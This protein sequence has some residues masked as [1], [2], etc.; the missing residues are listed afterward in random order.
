MSAVSSFEQRNTDFLI[1]SGGPGPVVSIPHSYDG[2]P[3]PSYSVYPTRIV[4]AVVVAVLLAVPGRGEDGD[5][6]G[7]DGDDDD[8]GVCRRAMASWWGRLCAPRVYPVVPDGGWGW[9]V[10]GALFSISAV[11]IGSFKAYGVFVPELMAHFDTHARGVSWIFS[12]CMFVVAFCAPVTTVLGNRFSPRAV[13][14][15]GGVITSVGTMSTALS[16]T[17]THAYLTLG[18][19]TGLG[20]SLSTLPCYSALSC[21]FERRRTLA[22]ALATTGECLGTFAFAPGFQR[23]NEAV[24]WRHS[25]LVIGAGQA[26]IVACGVLLRPLELRAPSPADRPGRRQPC[27]DDGAAVTAAATIVIMRENEQTRTTV[28][29]DDSGVCVQPPP[30]ATAASLFFPATAQP[31]VADDFCAGGDEEEEEFDEGGCSKAASIWSDDEAGAADDD[32]REEPA[33][34]AMTLLDLSVLREPGFACYA[35]FG[36]FISFGFFPPGLFLVPLALDAGV[37]ATEATYLLSAMAGAELVGRSAAGWLFSRP[38]ALPRVY[39]ELVCV[40]AVAVAL[41]AFPVAAAG[42]G[43][44]GWGRPM[45]A[46]ASCSAAFGL[47]FGAVAGTHVSVLAEPEVVGP[48]RFSSG[49]GV[50]VFVQSFSGLLG[51]PL[52]GWLVDLADEDYLMAFYTSGVAVA[53]AAICIALVRPCALEFGGGLNYDQRQRR[54]HRRCC[55]GSCCYRRNHKQQDNGSSS[56]SSSSRTGV[57]ANPGVLAFAMPFADVAAT[58]EL[59]E[60]RSGAVVLRAD[61][62]E[63]LETD[64]QDDARK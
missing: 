2:V 55:G 40:C 42:S 33:P 30:P 18:L 13:V 3:S 29:S 9:V 26:I 49:L 60:C 38:L 31:L 48:G 43:G 10:V 51:P 25:F 17:L 8:G 24:G 37:P 20:I 12:I 27:T 56:S 59:L 53:L 61:S 1:S 28:H 36:A 45:A 14:M 16:H 32:G 34:A 4:D 11:T 54:R 57:N 44:G 6:G 22:I 39:L 52:A 5:G 64:L 41:F 63:F 23:L 7:D 19:V 50:Y 35:L 21:Y 15:V 58:T 47:A 62:A 46:L